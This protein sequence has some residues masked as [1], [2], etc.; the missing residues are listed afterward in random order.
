MRPLGVRDGLV[1]E[2]GAL[3]QRVRLARCLL[4]SIGRL[5]HLLRV[6]LCRLGLGLLAAVFGLGGLRL[7]DLSPRLALCL[8]C[9][10]ALFCCQSLCM[11]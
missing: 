9:L 11:Q 8:F 4:S 2:D 3:D 6:L 10:S 1:L 7:F 5:E